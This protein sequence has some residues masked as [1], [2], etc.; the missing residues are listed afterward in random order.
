M[1]RWIIAALVVGAG[2]AAAQPA[3]EVKTTTEA[4]PPEA[5][6]HLAVSVDQWHEAVSDFTLDDAG[7]TYGQGGIGL[8]RLRA[9]GV[10]PFRRDLALH[11]EADLF[12]DRVYGDVP[13]VGT[14]LI[15]DRVREERRFDDG[16]VLPRALYLEWRAPFGVLRVGHQTS[17][18]GLGIV[19]NA[20]D[21][22][23]RLFGD[24]WRGSLVERALFATAP[25]QAFGVDP[26]SY[27]GRLTLAVAAD[28]VYA[29][30]NARLLGDQ[31]HVHDVAREAVASV[32]VRPR[33]N[34]A[35]TDGARHDLSG[36]LYAVRRW[37]DDADGHSLNVWVLDG[38]VR[39]LQEWSR[40][41][42]IR[43]ELEGAWITGDTD[44]VTTE[45]APSGVDVQALGVAFE[46]GWT[47][48]RRH[49][50]RRRRSRR[51]QAAAVHVPSLL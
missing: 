13:D 45:H 33:Q 24:A 25:A 42:A 21:R 36:G 31:L 4:A 19:A 32:F 17:A 30:E 2:P 26:E 37:Q 34:A 9:G 27:P 5:R 41:N 50:Q 51:R 10:W 7:R 44:R 47:W 18:W 28:L 16:P 43:Y 3:P 14:G 48:H 11:V 12:A 49:G 29:D 23:G 1:A 20:G 39:Y 22:D 35:P 8:T 40:T 15:D 38:H 6:P 46:M